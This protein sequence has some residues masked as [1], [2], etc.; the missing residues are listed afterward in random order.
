MKD[1]KPPVLWQ[2]QPVLLPPEAIIAVGFGSAYCSKGDDIVYDES[3]VFDEKYKTCGDM[4]QLALADPEHDWRIH[5]FAPL[6]EQVFQRHAPG[7]WVLIEKGKG[8]A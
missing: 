7:Q 4:E 6:Y 3:D 5:Y 1:K 8:F 2:G